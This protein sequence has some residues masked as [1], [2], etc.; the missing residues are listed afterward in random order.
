MGYNGNSG[1]SGYVGAPYNFIEMNS[2]VYGKKE[3]QPHDVIDPK[4]HTGEI[5][6]EVEAITPVMVDDGKG[7]FYTNIYSEMAI[8]GSTMRGLVRNNMQ[9]L[10]FSSFA[11]DI[12]DG[13][14]MYR[15]VAGG[16]DKDT[17]DDILGNKPQ[18]YIKA[19]GTKGNM[20]VL[21]NVKAGYI[22]NEGGKYSILPNVVDSQISEEEMDYYVINERKII[23][24]MDENFSF[25]L[26]HK[27]YIMQNHIEPAEPDKYDKPFKEYTKAG[28]KHYKGNENKE[29]HPYAIEVSYE[30]SG[31][32]NITAVDEKDKLSHNGYMLS[33]GKMSE[34]KAIYIIPEIDEGGDIIPIPPNKID[35]FKRD[36]EGRK[37]QVEAME[38][39][40]KG[41]F[42]L[43]QNGETKPVFYIQLGG[44]KLYFGFTP[45]LRIFYDKSIYDGINAE[46]KNTVTDY[47]NSIFGYSYDN[48]SYKT[49]VSFSDAIKL[50]GN[51]TSKVEKRVLGSPKPTSYLDYLTSEEN[52]AVSYNDDFELRGVKQYWLKG[53]TVNGEFIKNDNITSILRPCAKGTKFKGKIRFENLSDSELGMLLWSLLLEKNSNQN[54]GKG[55]PYGFGRIA[56][57]LNNL[58]IFDYDK[59]YGNDML[60]VK[61]YIESEDKSQEYIKA[62]KADMSA[63]LGCD[64][65]AMPRIKNFFL[66]KDK[67]QIPNKEQ[68]KYMRITVYDENGNRYNE[69]QRRVNSVV[70]LPTVSDVVEGKP[71]EAL[72]E[73]KPNN[74]KNKFGGQNKGYNNN[75]N[76]GNN[77]ASK[78][79]NYNGN[80]VK[81]W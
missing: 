67:T 49:R 47:C 75:K 78:S 59:M 66:M 72:K 36:Y 74:N 14:L 34:K 4:K 62:A 33:T 57:K 48:E 15:N 52:K 68:T 16:N 8:P 7:N 54:I 79:K 25:L 30:I 42:S 5:E 40:A 65:M 45:R 70:K 3:I 18:P 1:Y 13:R 50:S 35:Y 58:K 6:Y 38:K 69:Y 10:S 32:R 17:Y 39:G 37:N 27:P 60:S 46:Q 19:D 53:D 9:I 61:P 20:S 26:Y 12:Q 29:Y 2:K 81:K 73:S 23:E 64:V 21:K 11:G 71:L 76:K 44:E 51:E 28:M 56:V 55:K 77:G 43:P 41:F 63:F 80:N 24:S 22:R 31:T